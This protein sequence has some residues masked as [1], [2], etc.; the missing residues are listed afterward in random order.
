MKKVIGFLILA[1]SFGIAGN[2]NAEKVKAYEEEI[3]L[4]TYKVY[5][6]N[7]YPFFDMA[8]YYRTHIYPYPMQADVSNKEKINQKHRFLTIENEY[9]KVTVAPFLGGKLY[10]IYDKVNKREVLYTNHVV[11]PALYGIRGAW[12]SGGISF[13]FPYAHTITA[14]T[15]VDNTLKENP[16]GSASIIISNVERRYRM[17]WSVTLTLYPGK[18]Y[19][20][21]SVKLYN[22]SDSPH[23]YHFWS[24]C[25]VHVNEDCRMIYPAQR[26]IDH[27]LTAIYSWP[28]ADSIV[29]PSLK[30]TDISL[31]KNLPHSVALSAYFP[32]DNFFGY[33][34]YQ[35]NK[36]VAH[37]ADRNV[38]TGT[39]F[40]DFG[41]NP[42][43]HYSAAVRLTDNDGQYNEI[44]SSPFL[45]QAIFR[46]LQPHQV[47]A[48]KE[49]WFPINNTKGL[50]TAN[51]EAALNIVKKDATAE[52]L[53][54]V[55][56]SLKDA[57]LVVN[58]GDKEILK[59]SAS[60]EPGKVYSE[61]IPYSKQSGMI[62]VKLTAKDGKQFIDYA[63]KAPVPDDKLPKPGLIPNEEKPVKDMTPE[64]SY[65]RGM[66]LLRY[67]RNA[68]AFTYFNSALEKDSSHYLTHNVLGTV[69]YQRGLW[70]KAVT[71]F[72]TSL[73]RNE[74]QGVPHYYLGLI[75]K[76]KLE[77]DDAIR[78]LSIAAKYLETEA[79]AQY[80]LG[81]TEFMRNNIAGAISHF[82]ESLA[83]NTKETKAQNLLAIAYRKTGDKKS[84]LE[85][86]D[87]ILTDDPTNHLALWEKYNITRDTKY[88][89][90]FRELIRSNDHNYIELACDYASCGLYGDAC[91]VLKDVIEVKGNKQVSVTSEHFADESGEKFTDTEKFVTDN[92]VFPMVYYSL[93]YFSKMNDV[94][95]YAGYYKKVYEIKNWDYMFPSRLEDFT[96]LEDVIKECPD[97][98]LA[99]TGLGNLLMN[100]YREDE[101][102]ARWKKASEI[103]E[104]LPAGEISKRSEFITVIYRNLG[105]AYNKVKN[106]PKTAFLWYEKGLK[107]NPTLADYYRECGE[108]AASAGEIEKGIKYLE[109]VMGKINKSSL[110]VRGLIPLYVQKGD[111]DKIIQLIETNEFENWEGEYAVLNWYKD[112][113][114]R[115]ADK[116]MEK[117]ALEDAAKE[118]EKSLVP[119]KNIGD[120]GGLSYDKSYLGESK[121]YWKLGNL[122]KK[123]GNSK[124][125][126]EAFNK[127]VA[128][129]P[130]EYSLEERY[131]Y[132]L[133]LKEVGREKETAKIF[134][135]IIEYANL[136][137]I[138]RPGSVYNKDATA[139]YNFY[140][141]IAYKGKGNKNNAIKHLKISVKSYEEIG[142][143]TNPLYKQAKTML[144]ELK[145]K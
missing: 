59:K 101:A 88:L 106:D 84:A 30:G 99:Y 128:S 54:N 50:V 136:M 31:H 116:F 133:S 111:D 76:R 135:K 63:E 78:E 17:K 141:G 64:E 86:N 9:L 112:A 5:P 89:T 53:V 2:I 82:K 102:I 49:Q 72:E 94:K 129:V 107:Y 118:M 83:K 132:A 58:T 62:S 10:D 120:I 96:I 73:K 124:L 37:C 97:D 85:L 90:D 3:T 104:K 7:P 66:E 114:I 23:R 119:P 145:S 127:G 75:H 77:L 36:G 74:D 6:E 20:E 47:V 143:T 95:D 43:G 139:S 44:D 34:D 22:G 12:C 1:V 91:K 103:V 79:S 27:E 28:I 51:P 92:A 15:T 110:V 142:A 131:Y 41:N 123:L 8:E 24:I 80:Y 70:D 21:E 87:R 137:A 18:Y 42:Y 100:S 126:Q 140:M 48:W 68:E 115:K 45:T 69:Y 125:S 19:M 108:I 113:H 46:L 11:K 81:E 52:I 121:A 25:A 40:W 105:Y 65:V 29:E 35:I 38:L 130:P 93:G 14:F 32:T 61:Q 39:K 56:E 109:P 71:H 122:Y 67:E 55:N 98:Y 134:D 16:D 57:I 117:N 138:S 26:A 60:M 13:N 4:P 144:V 33:Y